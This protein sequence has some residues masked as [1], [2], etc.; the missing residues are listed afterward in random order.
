MS[1]T[2]LTFLFAVGVIVV[3]GTTLTWCADSIAEHTRM[4]KL[5]VG[6]VFLAAATSL[7]E[8]TT[9]LNAIWLD[10]PDLA[11]GD[12]LGSCLFNLLILACVDF[13]YRSRT[14]AL[15]RVAAAH[16]LAG[17]V[18]IALS[19][20]VAIG[21]LIEPRMVSWTVLG[22]GPAVLAVLMTYLVGVRLIYIDQQA[23]QQAHEAEASGGP[24]RL[25]LRV[26]LLGY[27]IAVVAVFLAAPM[28]AASAGQ[29]AELSGLGETFI[30][31]TLLALTTSLPE[32]VATIVA[33]RIGA[34]D[35]AIGNIFGSNALNIAILVPLDAAFPG[36]LLCAVDQIHTFTCLAVIL[37]T[38]VIVVG[39]LNRAEKRIMFIEPDA[40]FVILLV[41]VSLCV[42]YVAG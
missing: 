11:V 4:G 38:S 19:S 17:L 10:L 39:Q 21:I 36:S 2:F 6:S 37:I 22:I 9:D 18:T 12:L 33:V 32:L 26:A 20:V 14:R 8:L 29:I 13:V 3:A 34:A 27:L 1:A 25:S 5:F 35:L 30:G 31:V 28:L 16:S 23:S 40:A 41:V 15:S 24:R 7:P 42:L